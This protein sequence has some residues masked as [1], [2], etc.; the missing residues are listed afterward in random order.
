MKKFV[1][2]IITLLITL[3]PLLVYSDS[4]QAKDKYSSYS[5][6]KAHQTI[7]DDY[8]INSHDGPTSRAV[9][10]I[11][12]GKIELSTSELATTVAEWS[13]SDLYTFEGIKERHNGILHITSTHFNEPI[14]RDLVSRSDKTLSIHGCRGKQAMTYVGGRDQELAK[15]IAASLKAAGFKVKNPPARLDGKNRKNI[16]NKNAV[17]KGVQ[18]ELTLSQRKQLFSD[19]KPTATF[20]RYATAL[21]QVM[22]S[23]H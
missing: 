10:A 21:A 22:G 23:G 17:H 11:H 4:A 18:L 2:V 1:T 16:C 7:N 20:Y 3:L 12:G 6:L 8:R 9:I 19:E 15:K 13:G 14:A 5:R